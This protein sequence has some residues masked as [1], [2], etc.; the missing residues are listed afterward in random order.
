MGLIFLSHILVIRD[1][2]LHRLQG[3]R[4]KKIWFSRLTEQVHKGEGTSKILPLPVY[5]A[6]NQ[7]NLNTLILAKLTEMVS[8]L[9][10]H[11]LVL[12]PNSAQTIQH[13]PGWTPSCWTFFNTGAVQLE[14]SLK[15]FQTPSPALLYSLLSSPVKSSYLQLLVKI[16]TLAAEAQLVLKDETHNSN[17]WDEE[18]RS[19]EAE[20][21]Q[22]F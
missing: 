15:V 8:S 3:M 12:L 7:M 17:M 20:G 6:W 5:F 21:P 4:A 11:I 18:F 16:Y 9:R 19:M 1:A 13:L 2:R 10:Q 22:D 14:T